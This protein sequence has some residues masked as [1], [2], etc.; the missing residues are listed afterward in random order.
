MTKRDAVALNPVVQELASALTLREGAAR[1]PEAK[2]AYFINA[3]RQERDPL[4]ACA[5]VLVLATRFKEKSPATAH[6]L[7]TLVILAIGV[8]AG[9]QVLER[10]GVHKSETDKAL[11]SAAKMNTQAFMDAPKSKPLGAGLRRR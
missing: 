9:Q 1:V 7:L 10:S 8:K 3:L 11:Q 2:L 5:H 6:H 4:D